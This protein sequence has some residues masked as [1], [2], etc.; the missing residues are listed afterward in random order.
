VRDSDPFGFRVTVAQIPMRPRIHSLQSSAKALKPA[1]ASRARRADARDSSK[2]ST[3]NALL[4][5]EAGKRA[6]RAAA[7]DRPARE[8]HPFAA[9]RRARREDDAAELV[10]VQRLEATSVSPA[11]RN[12]VGAWTA[13]LRPRASR[14]R[15]RGGLDVAFPVGGKVR[16]TA[17]SRQH[18]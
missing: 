13:R 17:G 8:E 12:G 5:H 14:R 4:R 15:G 7:T 10:A 18:L 11:R 3:G 1:A 16:A 2:V 6:Y 9:P